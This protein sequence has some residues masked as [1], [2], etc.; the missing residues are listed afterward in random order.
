MSDEVLDFQLNIMKSLITRIIEDMNISESS[1]P[2]GARVAVMSYS[3]TAKRVIRFSDYLTK[4]TLLQLVK[5]RVLYER[6]SGQRDL[7]EAMTYTARHMF[8]RTRGGKLVTKMAIFMTS[9]AMWK[10]GGEGRG[11][12]G[13]GG[14]IINPNI[15]I[16]YMVLK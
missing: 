5:D 4:G 16:N 7:G 1:C 8:K 3:D 10:N 15:I 13:Q 6:T 9:M 12:G 11:V 14:L 2:A